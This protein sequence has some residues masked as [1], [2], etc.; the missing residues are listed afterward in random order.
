[1]AKIAIN[2]TSGFVGNYLTDFLK[3]KHEIVRIPRGIYNDIKQLQDKI[4]GCDVIINLAGA[5]IAKKWSESYKKELVSSRLDTTINLVKAMQNLQNKPKIFISTSAVGIY[6]TGKEHDE[7]S[8]EFDDGFLGEL[9]KKW[10]EEALKAKHLG[11]KTAIFRISV[12]IGKGGALEKMLPVFKLGL[13]GILGDGKQGFSWIDINDLAR[14][15][16]FVLSNELEGIYNLSSPNPVSNKEF[17]AALANALK[18]PAWFKVPEFALKLKFGE[19]AKILTQGQKVYPKN[20]LQNGFKFDYAK[21][22]DSL[23]HALS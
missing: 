4:E 22:E 10:E 5:S 20:L 16:E 9:S 2:G 8:Q 3:S 13:G 21:I 1:M 18:R 14:A 15:Y 12:V 11:I 23:K 19:G 7:S 17:T 6:K